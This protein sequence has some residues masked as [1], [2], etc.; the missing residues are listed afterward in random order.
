[1][2]TT[3]LAYQTLAWLSQKLP[4]KTI[5][6][7]ANRLAEIAPRLDSGRALIVERNLKRCYGNELGAKQKRELIS[8]VYKTYARYYVDS[9]RLVELSEQ[10]VLAG[11]T[12][13]NAHLITESIQRGK[14]TILVLPHVGGWEWAGS[15]LARC[16]GATVTAVVEPIANE[17][18]RNWMKNW[19][20]SVGM[21][22]LAIN[23]K[24]TSQLIERLRD[25]H[26]LCLLSDRN[27]GTGGVEVDFFGEKT[28]VPAGAATLA[29][30]TGA[31]ILPVA[32]YHQGN[33][34]H[35][36]VRPAISPQRTG[37]LRQDVQRLTQI[38]TSE[39]EQLIK[40]APTQWIVLQPNWPSDHKALKYQKATNA[41]KRASL[42]RPKNPGE[43][44]EATCQ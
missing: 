19:R 3:L 10:Q 4:H 32:V 30:R 31:T 24:I 40:K 5:R 18:L 8:E 29:L 39:L 14:G 1:M 27:L 33:K 16:V 2:N 34:N 44:Q 11:I 7:L 41:L 25:N 28:M 22:I 23:P 43:T 21:Q 12:T 38:I 6:Y 20:E 36:Y 15:W 37:R 13:E 17:E 9:A 26:V 35:V 42:Q